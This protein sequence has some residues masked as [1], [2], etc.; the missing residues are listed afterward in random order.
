MVKVRLGNQG[1]REVAQKRKAPKSQPRARPTGAMV[2][3]C[4][5]LDNARTVP[6]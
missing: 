6:P 5:R 2:A 1:V 4:C 3:I